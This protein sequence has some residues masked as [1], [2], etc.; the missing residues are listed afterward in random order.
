MIEAQYSEWTSRGH[1]AV[2]HAPPPM[3]MHFTG[4]DQPC[5]AF[6]LAIASFSDFTVS[7]QAEILSKFVRYWNFNFASAESCHLTYRFSSLMQAGNSP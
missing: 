6:L 4:C 1:S 3:F 7:A 5:S 2:K